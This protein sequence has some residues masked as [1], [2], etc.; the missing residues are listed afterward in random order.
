MVCVG[1]DII[2]IG[3][4]DGVD[5]AVESR[6]DSRVRVVRAIR[7][8]SMKRMRRRDMRNI[9]EGKEQ[10]VR[11]IYLANLILTIKLSSLCKL[12]KTPIHILNH[13]IVMR[14]EGDEVR[15]KMEVKR[16]GETGERG[17]RSDHTIFEEVPTLPKGKQ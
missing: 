4:G 15:G 11:L 16:R 14:R 8:E 10:S 1:D 6:G 5:S 2:D 9:Q 7:E 17:V 12:P 13:V 3:E